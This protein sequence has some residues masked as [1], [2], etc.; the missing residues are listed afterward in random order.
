MTM[1]KRI[2]ELV[3]LEDIAVK[4]VRN[5]PDMSFVINSQRFFLSPDIAERF[6]IS[7]EKAARRIRKSQEKL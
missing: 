7:L 2:E 5:A 6:A 4:V 3:V 1:P